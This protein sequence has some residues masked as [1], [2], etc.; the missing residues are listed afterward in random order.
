MLTLLV[1]IA[2]LVI[3]IT[4]ALHALLTKRDSKSALAWVSFCLIIPL[5]GPLIY[6]IFG[7]NRITTK[8]QKLFLTQSQEDNSETLREPEG[9]SF[10]PLSLVGESL[11]NLGLRSCNELEILENGEALYPQMLECIN[12]AKHRVYLCTYLFQ[13]DHTG[14]Q[15]VK[16]L[17]AAQ[18]RGVDVRVIVDGLGEFAYPPRIG[19]KLR[20]NKINFQLFNPIRFVPPSL[21]LNMRN[22]RKIMLVDGETAF[23]GGQNIGDRH[24]ITKIENTIPT[25][26]LHFRLSGKIVDDFERAFLKDWHQCSGVAEKSV[27]EVSN[28]ND[29]GSDIWTRLIL[30]GPNENLDKLNELLTGVLSSAHSRIWIMTPYFLPGADLLGA[31]L[32]AKLR[33]VDVRILLPERTNIHLAHWAAQ[34]NLRHILAKGLRV[35]SQPAPF[36]HTKAIIIDDTYSLIGSANLDARSLRLNFELG[37]EIFSTDVNRQLS[38][39]FERRLNTAIEI[40]DRQLRK[41][42]GWM[43]LRDACAWLFSP[44]L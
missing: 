8:A 18:L 35:Y 4:A 43:R 30:D 23:T 28:N 44:Y 7:I 31:L 21:H 36:I 13:N 24:L 11:T 22:H 5:F 19:K 17:L 39:Y 14:D 26:D 6:L 32:G 27:F 16:A 37:L 9:T 29:P 2:L 15:F 12:S 33:G 3:S 41:R 20:K 10:R 25:V 42:P 38:E 34:H 1:S 40:N